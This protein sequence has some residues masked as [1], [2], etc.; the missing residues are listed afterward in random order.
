MQRLISLFN[1]TVVLP[2]TIAISTG[3]ALSPAVVIAAETWHYDMLLGNRIIGE[4]TLREVK[5]A[6]GSVLVQTTQ[7]EKKGWF[8]SF[9]MQSIS[10][11]QLDASGKTQALETRVTANGKTWWSQLSKDDSGWVGSGRDLGT[12][13]SDVS[14]TLAQIDESILNDSAPSLLSMRTQVE[15]VLDALPLEVKTTVVPDM[16]FVTSLNALPFYL[17]KIERTPGAL[18]LLDNEGLQATTSPLVDL[19]TQSMEIGGA[20]YTARHIKVSKADDGTHIW[21][22]ASGEGPVVLMIAGKSGKKKFQISL[23]EDPLATQ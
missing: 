3:L 10:L 15:N 8:T 19:G 13:P 7:V 23:R 20:R 9:E 2:L 1:K 6:D 18:G 14:Q 5:H 4:Q 16:R 12:L 11:E 21:F 22:N 17:A